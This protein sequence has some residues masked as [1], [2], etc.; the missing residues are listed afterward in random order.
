MG[1]GTIID[2]VGGFGAG[3]DG[4][5]RIRYGGKEKTVLGKGLQ[6]KSTIPEGHLRGSIET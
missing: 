6:S 4:N 3:G 5:G 2:F 1:R